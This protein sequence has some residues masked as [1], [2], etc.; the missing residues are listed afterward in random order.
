MALDLDW[1]SKT[2]PDVLLVFKVKIVR[3]LIFEDFPDQRVEGNRII[4]GYRWR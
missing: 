2:N 1:C 4:I 3:R